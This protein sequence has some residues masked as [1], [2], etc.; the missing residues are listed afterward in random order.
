M[1]AGALHR[2]SAGLHDDA[3]EAIIQAESLRPK[4]GFPSIS[5][6]F[7]RPDRLAKA[8]FQILKIRSVSLTDLLVFAGT[9]PRWRRSPWNLSS[10][11]LLANGRFP[12]GL[13][14]V[15]AH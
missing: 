15:S 2:A 7:G 12:A 14:E 3:V 11:P 5:S 9:I 6:R 10:Q 13:A 8:R 1:S 4:P